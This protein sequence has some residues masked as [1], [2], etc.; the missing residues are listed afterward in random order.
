MTFV[1]PS[2]VF[3]PR[4]RQILQM[5]WSRPMSAGEINARIPDVTFGAVSQHLAR[6]RNA[7]AV[8]VEARGQS[9]IY[10]VDLTALG[11]L[12]EALD[13]MWSDSLA[14]LKATAE[15]DHPPRRDA[16]G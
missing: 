12:A 11:P 6:L 15:A 14:A 8:T 16:D 7:G 5:I 1:D 3:A 9:R 10:T 4:R 2:L 13:A